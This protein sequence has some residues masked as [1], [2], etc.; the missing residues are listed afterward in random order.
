M[1]SVV[2]SHARPVEIAVAVVEGD[3]KFLIGQ[4]ETGVPLAGLW[5]F[6]GGKVEPGE[7]AENAAIRECL[8]ETGWL[9]RI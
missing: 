5:E 1:S 4:R 3:G 6:P 2:N 9:V 7:P 8:E